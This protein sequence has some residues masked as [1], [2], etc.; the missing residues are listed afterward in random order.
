M[1][2]TKEILNEVLFIEAVSLIEK[3]WI[4]EIWRRKNGKPAIVGA[5]YNPKSWENKPI[6]RETF[7]ALCERY[8]D[9]VSPDW[10]RIKKA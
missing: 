10:I 3:G 8:H 2:Q 1:S 4:A 5:I 7:Y 9:T 6:S